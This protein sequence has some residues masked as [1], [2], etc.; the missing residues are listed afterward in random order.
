VTRWRWALL[1]GIGVIAT[2]LTFDRVPGIHACGVPNPMLALEM[3]TTPAELTAQLAAHCR[4]EQIAAHRV[5][6]WIDALV[7]IPVYTT[8]LILS[9]LALLGD[10]PQA[11]RLVVAGCIAVL[12]AALL[13]QIEGVQLFALLDGASP[14][15]LLWV[16][17]RGKFALLALAMGIAGWLL[18][19]RGGWRSAAGVAIIGGAL[20]TLAGLG[21]RTGLIMQ[22]N[23]LAWITLILVAGVCA[24]SRASAGRWQ[25]PQP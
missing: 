20:L 8:F 9:L 22:G 11:K 10:A 1:A 19:R 12:V 25:N 16:A 3:V 18:V 7:F 15:A 24:V 4:T 17:V 5:A 13:D 23:S 21:G 2:M 6:L 14:G